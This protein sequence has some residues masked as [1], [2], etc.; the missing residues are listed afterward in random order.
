MTDSARDYPANIH[1][2]G[3]ARAVG[4]ADDVLTLI[5]EVAYPPDRL[6]DLTLQLPAGLLTLG[7]KTLGSQ[8]RDDNRVEVRLRLS[9]LRREQRTALQQAFGSTT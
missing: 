1:N 2:R 4:Y 9:S 6:L 8:R 7:G 3:P 5:C